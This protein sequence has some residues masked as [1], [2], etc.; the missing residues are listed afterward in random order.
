MP[1]ATVESLDREGRGV[2]REN[3]KTIFIDGAL[4]GEVVEYAPYQ[5]KSSYELAQ[6]VRVEQPSA[7]RVLPRC[8]HFGVCGGCSIQHLEHH[9]QVAAK[10][11][12]LEDTLWHVGR[13]RPELM[14][15][16]IY[17]TPWGYR[18]RARLSVRMVQKKGGALVGFRERKSTYVADMRGC[19]VLPPQVA[20]LIPRLRELVGSLTIRERLP[21]IEVALGDEVL[22]LVLRVLEPPTDADR[23]A[24]KRFAEE[25]RL[26]FWLQPAGP[27]TVR[28]FWPPEA[29]QLAYTLPEFGVRL[30]FAPTEFT[31]VNHG[32]NQVL[33]RRA[34]QLLA[35]RPGER[36][37][38]FFCGLG[39]FTL[40]I[41][42]L[43]AEVTGYE[44]SQALVERARSNAEA[45]GLSCRFEMANL[46]EEKACL[47][48]PA[49]DKV[50]IDPPRDGAMELV[51]S[52][53]VHRPARIVYVSC[54]P[55]TLARDAGVL[56]SVLGYRLAAAGIANMFPQTSHVESMAL[57]ERGERMPAQ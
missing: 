22:V 20:A 7:E 40:P 1:V 35:P 48:L 39:N 56:V 12:V 50:L 5:K 51:K 52:F 38:D 27:D 30:P 8:A 34:M 13:V 55:A 53:A 14:L 47:A 42:S 33:V 37:G 29:P 21:Q 36:I 54:D 45:N 17:G 11:R 4:P 49:F 16:P 57:F 24:L 46:F 15:R 25:H 10:Q 9:A 32:L 28:P 18:Q 43:G 44:G 3:G 41:A 31:Q 6:L 19:E 23:E 26:Q 2:A